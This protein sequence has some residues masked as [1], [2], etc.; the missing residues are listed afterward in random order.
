MPLDL[1]FRPWRTAHPGG[2]HRSIWVDQALAL[3]APG[4]SRM[5]EDEQRCD[6][7]IVG[8][9]FTGLW[10]AHRLRD[11]DPALRISVVDADD[12]GTGASGRNSGAMSHWWSKLPTLL[13]LLGAEDARRVLQASIAVLADIRAF[14]GEHGIEC[15]L[16]RVPS[17]LTATATAE[18]GAWI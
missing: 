15:E 14:L 11:L 18:V 5:L 8:G 16:G 4:S 17:E 13:H 1:S 7:C 12:C 2:R 10:T 3:E 6:V 9:G